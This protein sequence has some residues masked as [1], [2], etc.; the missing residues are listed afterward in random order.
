LVLNRSSGA[1]RTWFLIM[2]SITS[3]SSAIAN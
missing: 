2:L 3:K 1:S